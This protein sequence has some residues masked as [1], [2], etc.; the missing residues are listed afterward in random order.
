MTIDCP[1]SNKD[2][3]SKILISIVYILLMI[4]SGPASATTQSQIDILFKLEILNSMFSPRVM[5]IKV[6]VLKIFWGI[7]NTFEPYLETQLSTYWDKSEH[8]QL[9]EGP[10]LWCRI[11]ND[12]S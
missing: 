6:F 7:S 8:Y 12:Q 2:Y 10:D 11:L 1:F 5:T 9:K 4:N 3:T